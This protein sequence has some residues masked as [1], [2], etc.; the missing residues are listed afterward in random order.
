M[1]KGNP[2]RA[3]GSG[4]SALTRWLRSQGRPCWICGLPIDYGAP[5]GTPLSFNCDE[6]LPVA[7][8]GSPYSKANVDAAHAC[9]NGWRKTKGVGEVVAARAAVAARFGG[10]SSPPDFVA[11]AKAL[12]KGPPAAREKAFRAA[13]GDGPPTTTDWL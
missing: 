2:R 13:T 1:A 10:W 8:G 7:R 12:R 3:N 9:C 6:L 4:R 5:P 11:K